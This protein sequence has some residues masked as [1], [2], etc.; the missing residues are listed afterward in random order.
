M[1]RRTLLGAALLAACGFLGAGAAAAPRFTHGLLWRVGHAG[2]PPSY[3]FGT[4]HLADPRALQ[5]PDPVVAALSRSRTF[6]ME[7]PIGPGHER[8]MYEGAQ[9]DDGRRLEPLIGAEAYARIRAM[10][11]ARGIPDR[12][13]AQ[14]KPWAA[15]A[16]IAVT[17]EG[18]ESET[19]DQKLAAMALARHMHLEAL[20]GTEEHIAVFDGIPMDSQIAMLKHA[21]ANRDYLASM[22][23]PTLEAWLR[24]DLAGIRAV[25]RRIVK[26][27]PD[28]APHYAAFE[29][30]VV[31]DRNAAMAHRLFLPL[32]R[33][34][35]FVAVGAM[36]LYGDAGIL[37]LIEQQGYRL[38]RVY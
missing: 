24:R 25:D 10:L 6:A 18:Y 2:V 29:K 8:G 27:F 35:V 9:F 20:E 28:M 22:I 7:A 30:H 31:R 17:P 23:E 16:N 14:L 1:R 33:G 4:I 12:V 3:V 13:I 37:R 38:T 15:L 19:L 26:R 36:H 11:A 21:L 5:L 34:R 32:R